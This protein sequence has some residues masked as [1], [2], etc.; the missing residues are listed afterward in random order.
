MVNCI[1]ENHLSEAQMII[2]FYNNV[3]ITFVSMQNPEINDW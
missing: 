2:V 1:W 3:A